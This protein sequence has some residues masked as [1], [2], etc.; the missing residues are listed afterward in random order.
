MGVE[1]GYWG[2][3]L[4]IGEGAWATSGRSKEYSVEGPSFY[5]MLSDKFCLAHTHRVDARSR[6]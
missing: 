6:F 2:E 1:T 5:G 3:A 4:A